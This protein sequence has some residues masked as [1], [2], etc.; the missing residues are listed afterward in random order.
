MPTRAPRVM[1]V[2][3]DPDVAE[4]LA[5]YL[6][7]TI[8]AEITVARSASQAIQH[9]LQQPH[10][11]VLADLLLPDTD[12]LNLTRQLNDLGD[13][14]VVLMTGQPT[15]GRAVEAMRLGVRELF[16]KP[17]DLSRLGHVLNQLIRDQQHK[18]LQQLRYRR[19][20]R[21]TRQIVRQR[22]Q[23]R[24]QLELLCCDLVQAYHGLA[25]KV[26]QLQQQSAGRDSDPAD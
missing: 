12:G 18:Q 17:F 1:I 26:T 8:Q 21:L 3:D 22:R 5:D 13:H 7:R 10:D 14:Q 19:L 20:R 2:E 25:R 4:M 23:L 6:A 16:V 15:L 9:D 24:R 11:V